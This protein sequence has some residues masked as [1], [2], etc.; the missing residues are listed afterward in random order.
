MK[1]FYCGCKPVMRIQ[2][3]AFPRSNKGVEVSEAMAE[4][5]LAVDG[6]FGS[7]TT[8]AKKELE[9][10][11]KREQIEK[12]K[13]KS[14]TTVIEVPNVEL[15]EQK[16]LLE[17]QIDVLVQDNK[18]LSNELKTASAKLTALEM[19]NKAKSKG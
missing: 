2:R 1:I 11:T 14:G 3:M 7:M 17:A 10:N 16:R 4:K 13:L 5:L 18:K 19:T 8:D 9:F 6:F 12:D 15:I